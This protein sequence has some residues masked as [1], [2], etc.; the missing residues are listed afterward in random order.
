MST[1]KTTIALPS[2]VQDLSSSPTNE[3]DSLRLQFGSWVT[4]TEGI[5]FL[6][7]SDDSDIVLES[8]TSPIDSTYPRLGSPNY[9]LELSRKQTIN[10]SEN[11]DPSAT[12]PESWEEKVR[13]IISFVE[14]EYLVTSFE[15]PLIVEEALNMDADAPGAPA[16]VKYIY[17]Y[18]DSNY[19]E[20][21]APVR[22][23]EVI[24]NLYSM[25]DA[26]SIIGT[27]V[28]GDEI[29][30]VDILPVVRGGK[31]ATL[32]K[33]L[34]FNRSRLSERR[35]FQ[36]QIVP[37]ENMPLLADYEGSKYLFPMYVDI[38]IPLDKNIEFVKLCKDT[39]MGIALTRDVEGV[40]DTD[41]VVPAPSVKTQNMSFTT[42]VVDP[43]GEEL[44]QNSSI[45]VKVVDLLEWTDEDAPAYAFDFAGYPP[46]SNFYF[47][48][49]EAGSYLEGGTFNKSIA[50]G[51][52]STLMFGTF[53]DTFK[54]GLESIA[55]DKRKRIRG[56]FNGKESYSETVMYKI[57]KL[58][59]PIQ[60]PVQAP[61][62]TYHFMNS[63]EVEE[64]LNEDKEFKFVD[65]QVK[66]NQEYSYIVT[67][68]QMIVGERYVYDNLQIQERFTERRTASVD[69]HMTPTIKLVEFPVFASTGRILDNPP[70]QP[71]IR[72]FPVVS[73]RNKL[74]MFFTT[75]TGNEDIAPIAL[76]DEEQSAY[77]Q[78]AI[79]Q[80]R[81]DGLI[82]F[83]SDDSAAS[84]QIYRMESPPAI[85]EDFANRLYATVTTSPFSGL[86]GSSATAEIAQFA[87]T[88]YYYMFRTIDVHGGISNPSPIYEIEL[89]NDGGAG[90]PIIRHYDLSSPN[91]K[92]PT[93]SA[94]KIIQIIPRIAQVF[95]NEEASGLIDAGAVQPASGNKNIVL[96]NQTEPLFGKKF[97][98]RLTSKSTGKKVDLNVNFKTKR[99]QGEIE[100]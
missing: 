88:K 13:S 50:V 42:S 98:I 20:L 9:G 80:N 96:G 52:A 99:L 11:Q 54:Q 66:F 59:G 91:P 55:E 41:D 61:I 26:S 21:L 68:Y 69:V 18:Y 15:N 79:N 63:A 77:D 87:N 62:Q 53:L 40:T 72:F 17:N 36:N 4:T 64:F 51:T 2:V 45:P 74:K 14:H 85:I 8:I 46:P 76:N 28:A 81:N 71:E 92:T 48:G 27:D 10:I 12:T 30:D 24:Q 23:H 32:S 57:Q 44:I 86:P 83:K 67:A 22:N 31:S 35:K 6:D 94:R 84:F 90:Y 1:K 16:G 49:A 25:F 70:L 60:N 78:V 56:I 7:T 58:E 65:T 89:Y 37:I 29:L 75:S 47:I 3:A 38:N 5:Q 95:L 43:A 93:K 73:D 34:R 39:S 33:A 97:K 19:E 82:T 100:S